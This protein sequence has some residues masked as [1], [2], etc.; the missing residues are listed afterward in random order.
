MCTAADAFSVCL[1]ACQFSPRDHDRYTWS[2]AVQAAADLCATQFS[3]AGRCTAANTVIVPLFI[4]TEHSTRHTAYNT[5][6]DTPYG[7]TIVLTMHHNAFPHARCAL[8][9]ERCALSAKPCSQ[10]PARAAVLQRL[11]ARRLHGQ[12]SR[13]RR[14]LRRQARTDRL[15]GCAMACE[16]VCHS[17]A[18]VWP[19]LLS[20][21]WASPLLFTRPCA[22]RTQ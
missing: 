18:A 19:G 8:R 20:T 21:R 15:R 1:S 13:R 10:A 5:R 11:P 12:P 4:Y 22:V 9:A 2:V 17:G 3:R 7:T 6:R 16:R 14:V